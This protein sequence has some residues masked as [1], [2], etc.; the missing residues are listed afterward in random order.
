MSIISNPSSEVI[1][2]T[3]AIAIHTFDPIPSLVA[4][5]WAEIVDILTPSS[6]EVA[7]STDSLADSFQLV[8]PLAGPSP[9]ADPSVNPLA[10]PSADPFESFLVPCHS[11]AGNFEGILKPLVILEHLELSFCYPT[12]A[13]QLEHS[14]NSDYF[15]TS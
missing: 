10:V 11:L 1:D 4:A 12:T 2:H 14:L 15:A 13:V 7:P 8:N 9:L 6:F 3:L 5:S